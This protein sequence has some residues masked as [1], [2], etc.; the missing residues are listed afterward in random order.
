M[1]TVQLIVEQVLQGAV[2]HDIEVLLIPDG[3]DS[4]EYQHGQEKT[5][6]EGP[7]KEQLGVLPSKPRPEAMLRRAWNTRL[8]SSSAQPTDRMT[9]WMSAMTGMWVLI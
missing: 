3:S 8:P 2:V 6:Y 7:G 5:E 4:R 1:R 9:C